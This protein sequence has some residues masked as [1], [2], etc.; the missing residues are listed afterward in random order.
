[1]D[2]DTEMDLKFILQKNYN[3]ITEQYAS[4]IT[5]IRDSLESMQEKD[6]KTKKRLYKHLLGL[7][8]RDSGDNVDMEGHKLLSELT[9]ELEEA[10]DIDKIIDLIEENCA[11][12]L[13]IWIFQNI[14]DQFHLDTDQEA[15]KYPEFLKQY[16]EKHKI[17]EIIEKIP[18]F[19]NRVGEYT[20]LTFKLNIAL[21]IKFSNL[22]HIEI[23]IAQIL[24]ISPAAITI[25]DIEE[26]CVVVTSCIPTY[27]AEDIFTSDKTF[28]PEEEEKFR[29]LSVLWLQCGHSKKYIFIQ[30]DTSNSESEDETPVLPSKQ[31]CDINNQSKLKYFPRK[32]MN[33]SYFYIAP[34]TFRQELAFP[35]PGVSQ[36][37]LPVPGVSQE[38]LPVPGV[39]QESLP[40]PGVSQESTTSLSVSQELVI[41][42]SISQELPTPSGFKDLAGNEGSFFPNDPFPLGV[43]LPA[44]DSFR[45]PRDSFR[46]PRDSFR[47]PRDNFRAP[48]DSFRAPRDNFRAPRDSFRA[49]NADS[50]HLGAIVK[51]GSLFGALQS[52][53]TGHCCAKHS[54]M[55]IYPQ[56]STHG[57][58][59]T[60]SCSDLKQHEKREKVYVKS[61]KSINIINEDVTVKATLSVNRPPSHLQAHQPPLDVQAHPAYQHPIIRD[62]TPLLHASAFSKI[63]QH[64]EPMLQQI[65]D[66]AIK[67]P[68]YFIDGLSFF[69]CGK[70][71]DAKARLN[72]CIEL[73]VPM[74]T[75]ANGDVSLCNVYLGDTEF[76]SRNF[77]VAADHYKKAAAMYSA[78][79]MA[80]LFRMVPPS[81]SAIH[82][83]CGSALRNASKMVDGVQ[84]YKIAI[85]KALTDKDKLAANTSLGNLYQSLGENTSA[86]T[87]YEESVLLSEKLGDYISL[88]WAHGNMGNAY[89]GLF[90][91]DKALYHLQKSLDL[92]V[93]YEPTPQAIGRTYNNLG[94][95]YQSLSELD[96]AQEHYDLALSKAIYGRDIPGQAEL[97]QSAKSTTTGVKFYVHGLNFT[98]IK[99]DTYPHQDCLVN[100]GKYEQA[101]LVAEQ[102]RARTLGELM[103]KRKGLSLSKKPLPFDQIASMISS[104]T[105][106]VLYLSYT[107]ARLL[108]WVFVP[109]DGTVR[110]NMFEVPLSDD[111]FE[112]Q[113]FDYVM[114]SLERSFEMYRAVT[115]YE[116]SSTPLEVLYNLIAKP[117]LCV[118]EKCTD[119]AQ[120][121]KIVVIPDHFTALL[122]YSSLYSPTSGFFGDKITFQ[123]MPSLLTM[124]VLNQLPDTNVVQLPADAQNMC[125]AGNPTIP[126]FTYQNEV[127]NLSKLPHAKW[128]AEWVSHILKTTPILNEQATKS[129]IVMRIMSAKVI[130]LA[131]HSST[132]AGFL[133]FGTMVSGPQD[134]TVHHTNVLLFPEEVE[135]LNI[136]P[137]LVV[138]STCESGRGVVKADGIQGMARA[139]ILAG[140][141]AVL[142]TLWRVPDE[143]AAIFMQFFYQYMMDGMESTLALR[144]A[145]LSIRCF[146]KY[147]QYIY[148]S[149]YQLTGRDV[150][151]EN[152]TPRSIKVLNQRLGPGSVF[153][154]LF[155]VKTL[156]AALV[157][158]P[159]PPTDV[160]VGKNV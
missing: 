98:D 35:V 108:G 44:R 139:F 94:T 85:S 137:A 92:T 132:S 40:V 158:D 25:Q 23:A 151:F 145:I 18:K 125:I 72:T 48:R 6:G 126:M 128:E 43:W 154:R 121:H 70:Y 107:G 74:G 160:Q 147:S 81:L 39:S 105:H 131:T 83:K 146:S 133:A 29:L 76:N 127:W 20:E 47:A 87:H 73:C 124:G 118:L 49:P 9:S 117:L 12:Y 159:R 77:V 60:S 90:Q 66:V 112:G 13:N 99:E 45:A 144:K 120:V 71:D 58:S 37:S 54:L 142:T 14:V 30:S 78:V 152:S 11:T 63:T 26:G 149:G 113:S 56:A 97:Q 134:M 110:I 10:N 75:K 17:S 31:D 65:S 19:K 141:Q 82:A 101:L 52:V 38:S 24:G 34:P 62:V 67:V 122:P 28:S 104:T 33:H 61:Y 80:A 143:S 41:P 100:L 8:A 64:V 109:K 46:A 2:K 140:A 123:M 138:L 7:R 130:H 5:C 3:Q 1:M 55:S 135:Q 114:Y 102:S 22:I 111:Q 96:K 95:A 103:L 86:L 50:E 84:E 15:L 79:N 89:L 91:K 4:Y 129:D 93:E 53:N 115:S 42:L 150:R 155:V 57:V 153:P 27:V 21:T 51:R 106:P 32:Q 157:S 156:E 36:E 69:K 59:T 136:S 68:L 16:F 116:E 88:G 148:W 119:L